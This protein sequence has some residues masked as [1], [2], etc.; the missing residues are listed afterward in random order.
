MKSPKRQIQV[1]GSQF[2]GSKVFLSCSGK[3]NVTDERRSDFSER[4]H[5]GRARDA[6]SRLVGFFGAAVTIGSL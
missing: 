6:P 2:L 1:V 4:V 5:I 3:S